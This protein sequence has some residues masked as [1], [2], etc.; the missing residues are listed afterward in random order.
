MFQLRKSPLTHVQ[1]E[2]G[3]VNNGLN[4]N[5]L[6]NLRYYS[7]PRYTCMISYAILSTFLVIQIYHF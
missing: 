7:V 4:V 1:S 6:K 2:T 5:A 3:I